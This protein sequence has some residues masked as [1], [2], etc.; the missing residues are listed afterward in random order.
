M[1]EAERGRIPIFVRGLNP[2][3]LGKK[4]ISKIGIK[5]KKRA[6]RARLELRKTAQKAR[7]LP[8]DQD[9]PCGI[10]SHCVV[11]E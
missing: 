2:R 6:A 1:N 5:L 10:W 9:A 11:K 8:L 7:A 3:P 4:K